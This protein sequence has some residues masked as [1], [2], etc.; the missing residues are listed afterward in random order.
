MLGLQDESGGHTFHLEQVVTG[1][2]C[3]GSPSCNPDSKNLLRAP[4]QLRAWLVPP[5]GLQLPPWVCLQG[6][7]ASLPTSWGRRHSKGG[8]LVRRETRLQV[9]LLVCHQL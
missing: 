8:S 1:T 4:T 5:G 7:E 6:M 2:R 3:A 9:L